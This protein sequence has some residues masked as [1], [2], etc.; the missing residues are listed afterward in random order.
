[1]LSNFILKINSFKSPI[2]VGQSQIENLVVVVEMEV[3]M[4]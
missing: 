4:E 2:T 1:M 3:E